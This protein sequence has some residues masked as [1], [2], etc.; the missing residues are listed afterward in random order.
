M[1]DDVTYLY[2]KEKVHVDTCYNK[3]ANH[4]TYWEIRYIVYS[5]CVLK[6]AHGEFGFQG[7]VNAIL[8][9]LRVLFYNAAY[10]LFWSNNGTCRLLINPLSILL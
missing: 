7:L 2:L 9:R 3:K 1:A 10:I 4:V 8:K 6:A 5:A